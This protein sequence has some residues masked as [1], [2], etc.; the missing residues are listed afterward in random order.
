MTTNTAWEGLTAN[1]A[2]G[3]PAS[4][5]TALRS[6]KTAKTAAGSFRGFRSHMALTSLMAKSGRAGTPRFVP[7]ERNAGHS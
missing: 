7:G 2:C 5:P 6:A 4:S 1:F 3:G